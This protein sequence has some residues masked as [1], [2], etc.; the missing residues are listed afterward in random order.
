MLETPAADELIVRASRLSAHQ[1]AN[2]ATSTRKT[3]GRGL[4]S[5]LG[6]RPRTLTIANTAAATALE[7]A[8]MEQEMRAKVT[9]LNE[10]VLSSAVA[11]AKR[12]GRD[13]SGVQE[14]WQ[15]FQRAAD[16]GDRR[17]RHRAFRSAK[18]V[19]RRGMGLRLTRQWPMASVGAAWALL[20]ILTWDEATTE[21]PY[22]IRDREIL[23]RPWMTVSPSQV[24]LP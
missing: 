16:S 10:A 2:L 23:T 12:K 6:R 11:I 1:I 18:R 13:T 4:R 24:D 19:F 7:R 21:G 3:M 15:R 14:A 17:E 20:G 5:S 9:L 22:T 8:N